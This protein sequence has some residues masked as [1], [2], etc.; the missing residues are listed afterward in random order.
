[1]APAKGIGAAGFLVVIDAE[2]SSGGAEEHGDEATVWIGEEFDPVE[3]ADLLR[4]VPL[5]DELVSPSNLAY[6]VALKPDPPSKRL[7]S[8]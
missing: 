5:S 7:R 3:G 1:M 8:P 4:E 2:R 6:W